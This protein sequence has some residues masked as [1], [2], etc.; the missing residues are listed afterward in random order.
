MD[1][2]TVQG[3]HDRIALSVAH[4]RPQIETLTE[5][6]RLVDL[7]TEESIKP[8]VEMCGINSVEV[9][10]RDEGTLEQM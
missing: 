8:V 4:I 5:L 3:V 2:N 9:Q 10:R 6:D 7:S 1:K